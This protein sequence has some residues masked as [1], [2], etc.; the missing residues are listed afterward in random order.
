MVAQFVVHPTTTTNLFSAI[1]ETEQLYIIR[2]QRKAIREAIRLNEPVAYAI[3]KSYKPIM[4]LRVPS[5]QLPINCFRHFCWRMYR[6]A[7]KCNEKT[8]HWNYCTRLFESKTQ[9]TLHCQWNN[10]Q[11]E[12]TSSVYRRCK[13]TVSSTIGLRSNSYALVSVC[14]RSYHSVGTGTLLYVTYWVNLWF[15][16]N[17]LYDILS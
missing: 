1:I 16:N 14:W 15:S 6:L 17:I 5:R 4:Y 12:S 13:Q 9:A 8:N 11:T 3:T 7:T 2:Q 10:V